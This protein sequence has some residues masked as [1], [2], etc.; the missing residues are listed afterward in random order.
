M[1]SPLLFYFVFAKWI[2]I[3]MDISLINRFIDQ[4][5]QL[6]KVLGYRIHAIAFFTQV[7]FELLEESISDILEVQ[8]RAKFLKYGYR[9]HQ[10]LFGTSFTVG[11]LHIDSGKYGESD[12]DRLVFLYRIFK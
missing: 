9:C 4:G 3:R 1:P 11:F 6:A 12:I 7:G 8:S 10:V 2:S 5:T